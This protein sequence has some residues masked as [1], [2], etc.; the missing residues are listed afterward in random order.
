MDRQVERCG[1]FGLK[2][3]DNIFSWL[4]YLG[5]FGRAYRDY[6]HFEDELIASY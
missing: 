1:R 5:L 6:V 2:L 3:F 4:L